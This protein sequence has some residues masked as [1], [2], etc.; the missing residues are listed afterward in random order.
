MAYL[1]IVAACTAADIVVISKV[2]GKPVSAEGF[3]ASTWFMGQIGRAFS[4][5]DLELARL[6]MGQASRAMGGFCGVHDIIMTPT[7]AYPPIRIG[8]LDLKP[9]ERAGLAVL[10]RIGHRPG[11]ERERRAHFRR[12]AHDI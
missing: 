3:E 1:T 8:E 10:R 2:T 6:T 11:D 9:I 7:M 5:A 4:A 12:L